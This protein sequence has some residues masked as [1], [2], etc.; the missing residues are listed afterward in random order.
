LLKAP[1]S[2]VDGSVATRNQPL[3]DSVGQ[4]RVE[5]ESHWLCEERE[6]TLLDRCG[7]ELERSEDVI[8]DHIRE[9]IEDLLVGTARGQLAQDS[10]DGYTQPPD[11]RQTTHLLGIDGYALIRHTIRVRDEGSWRPADGETPTDR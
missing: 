8:L 11:A 6:F 4:V 9:V 1:I 10:A 5:Q 3:G 2:H 7:G